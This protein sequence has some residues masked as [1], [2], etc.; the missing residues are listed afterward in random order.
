M[1]SK[2]L[3]LERVV[4]QWNGLSREVVVT[5]P[6]V[7]SNCVVV[8]LRDLVSGHGVTGWQLDTETL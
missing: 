2:D 7:F 6:E 1:I 8:A 5:I 3:F 4:R